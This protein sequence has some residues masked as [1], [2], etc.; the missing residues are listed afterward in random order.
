MLTSQFTEKID[1]CIHYK[2]RSLTIPPGGELSLAPT[3][4][5]VI[6]GSKLG[7]GE[8]FPSF[9]LF[10]L[11]Y[12]SLGFSSKLSSALVH[13]LGNSEAVAHVACRPSVLEHYKAGNE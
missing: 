11:R 13:S 2:L 5:W 4:H 9:A 8:I 10:S 12:L 6:C 7:F 3:R 1:Q